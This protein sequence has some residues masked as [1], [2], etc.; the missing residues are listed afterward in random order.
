[1]AEWPRAALFKVLGYRPNRKQLRVRVFGP[2]EI[3]IRAGKTV[4]GRRTVSRR[5][6][7]KVG[8]KPK[9]LGRNRSIRVTFRPEGALPGSVRYRLKR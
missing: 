3:L 8:I 4:V 1:L 9:L 6:T 2:G 5:G 7:H